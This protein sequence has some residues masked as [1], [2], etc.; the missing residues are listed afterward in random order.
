MINE[1]VS[2]SAN[3]LTLTATN[4]ININ[5]VM[6]ANDTAAL[7]LEPG[8]GKVNVALNGSGFTGRVDFF[9]A[10]GATPRSGSGFLTIGGTAYTVLTSLGS[11]GSMTGT[12]L[13]GM[14][15]NLARHYALG[16]DIDASATSGWNSGAGFTPV[17]YNPA[18]F[19][20]G[21]DGLGHT[22]DNLYINRPSISQIGMFSR[23]ENS[24]LRNVGLVGGSVTGLSAGSLLGWARGGVTISNAYATGDVTSPYGAGGLVNAMSRSTI[25]NSYATGNVTGSGNYVG[26]LVGDGTGTISNSYA[27]GSVTGSGDYVGGLAGLFNLSVGIGTISNSFATGSVTGSGDYVGGLVGLGSQVTISNSYATGSVSGGSSVGG[28]VGENFGG[29]ISN[30]YATG[31]VS[32]SGAAGGLAGSSTGTTSNSFWDTETSGQATSAGGTGK[33]T[34]EMQSLATF[35]GAGWSIDDSGGSGAVWRIYDGSTSPLLRSFLTPLE[36]Q[37]VYDGSGTALTDIGAY[38]I[39][40]SYDAGKVFGSVADTLTLSSSATDGYTATLGKGLYSTQQGY[41]LITARSIS[42]PG[43]AAGD[44]A[45]TNAITW[46]S[47]TLNINTSGAITDTAPVSGT[48]SAVF[49]LQG[50]TW[51]Q[52]AAGLPA[53]DVYDFGISGGTFIRALSGNGSGATPYQL[54]DVYG[55]QG[56]GSSGMPG[57][58]YQLAND[59]DATATATWNAGAGFAPVGNLSTPFTGSFDGVNHTITDL[60]I[61]RV[62]SDNVG[63]FGV[64]EGSLG[65]IRLV[66]V[67]VSG[68]NYVGGLAGWNY[69]G[70]ISNSYV[71]TAITGQT[72]V[73]GLVGRATNGTIS[74]SYATG[75]VT[76]SGS[77]V[78]GLVGGNY[79]GTI[80]TSYATDNVSGTNYV[81]GLAG[82]STGTI[83]DAYA[84]GSVNGSNYVGG[85]VGGNYGAGTISNA[86]ATGIV[87]G[88]V[89][90]IGGLVGISTG[91]VNTS[92]WDTQTSGQATSAAGTGLTTAE[93][94]SLATFS[95]A[96]WSIDDSGGSGATWR[97]YDGSTYPL[98]R[99][100]LTPLTVTADNVVKGY[101]GVPYTNALTN[102][103]YSV[104]G[105]DSS[106]H[107]F[108]LAAPYNGALAIGSYLPDLWSDQMGYDISHIDAL[109]TINKGDQTITFNPLADKTFGDADFTVGASASSG[110][111]VS[112][113]STTTGVCTMS[114]S[115][116]H[117]VAPGACSIT[118]S[119][120]GDADYNIAPD[121]TRSFSV[122]K[123]NQTITFTALAD[124]TYGDP[125]FTVS[126]TATSGL[127]V[128]FAS[129]TTTVCTVSG[130][131]VSIVG[132]G[133]C[134]ITAAQ[135]GDADY[136][137]SNIAQS[138]TVLANSDGDTPTPTDPPDGDSNGD[139]WLMISRT[140][141]GNANNN[142]IEGIPKSD[143]TYR[144]TANFFAPAAG[145]VWL[146]L[147]GYPVVM[148]C[149]PE[150]VDFSLPVTCTVERQLGPSANHNYH[151][152]IRTGIDYDP[153]EEPLLVSD[154]YPGPQVELLNG[155][156]MVGLARA[157]G[158]TGLADLLGSDS[159]YTWIST[160]LSGISNNGYYE[161]CAG[162]CENTPGRGYFMR[163]QDQ[164]SL[165]D[166]SS[167]PDLSE[168]EF[169]MTLTP[170][171]N[172]I[173]N[174]YGGQV[175]LSQVS[176]Q[177]NDEAPIPWLAACGDN[178]L[179]NAIY[180]YQGED[181][182][183]IYGFES[184]DGDHGAKLV[185]W[186]AYWVYVVQDNAEYKLIIPNPFMET[187]R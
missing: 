163:R 74:T 105:A 182:G 104:A 141:D 110:L 140:D 20:G 11:E 64:N 147:D 47:G 1:S 41:D 58:A 150:P 95:G 91:I 116:V 107:L 142:L 125:D 6:T 118:A 53:F 31:S 148:D 184:A 44:I 94:Q 5:A 186:L 113:V 54:T 131:T 175:L 29:N 187:I 70:S 32:G 155:A 120:A 149:G 102:P 99:G 176:V 4:D 179:F 45:L 162:S 173:A 19:T 161:P 73:G 49:D 40:G 106:G 158:E 71:A 165:P 7:D 119:Q 65:D 135:A 46:T 151:A 181:W 48:G 76:A 171:W 180:F 81:G 35:S 86:Y 10:D 21:F 127:A 92:F 137:A 128:S 112:F 82:S 34:A 37:P 101:D 89:S 88:I 68:T 90:G 22:I 108:N 154:Q 153:V 28:L 83:T 98:L 159:I 42:T 164:A 85:L 84:T 69:A 156:N 33:T 177:V 174:P 103:S 146:I 2:W 14:S 121:V 111:T 52:I 166:F 3:T 168:P 157:F 56:M 152:E 167:Y 25:S 57:N 24:T 126:A 12:D 27:T 160:G 13:Q 60:T 114:G 8:S 26:G 50:G 79:G 178:L 139:D 133:I 51:N 185:P 115:T 122:N 145:S 16:A 170:G 43:S 123:K 72:M 132:A 23:V 87:S 63:L 138:F 144:F 183:S 97:I 136:A 55:L 18:I 17:G 9:E 30:S 75:S 67:S 109:L 66:G 129:T 77:E 36:V 172:L 169:V 61:N 93:M 143:I 80:N 130:S 96:G 59:I 15:G 62:G 117:L 39:A 78:G 124:K 100:F 134:S 38:T